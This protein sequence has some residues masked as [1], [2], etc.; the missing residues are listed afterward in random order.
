MEAAPSLGA[1]T[2]QD[3]GRA[4]LTL[5]DVVAQ[6]VGFIGPVFSAAFLLPSVAGLG[7]TGKGAGVASPLALIV[8]T[9]G[10]GGVAWIISRYAS[11]IHA[12]G[13]L[14]DYVTDGFGQRVGFFAGWIYYGGMSLL[15]FAIFPAFGGFMYLTLSGN[16]GVDI[17]WWILAL[18]FIAVC[19]GMTIL[20]VQISTRAQFVLAAVS[21]AVIFGWAVYVLIKGGT[22][23]GSAKPFDPGALGF[24]DLIYGLLYAT[25]IFT[26]FESAAN[27]A[28]ET[29]DPRR[30]IPR[31]V[32]YSVIAVGVFYVIVMY[33]LELA[34]G[35]DMAALLN[36]E[37]FP[38]LYSAAANPEIGGDTFGE[39]VQWIV[40]I[41]IAAVALGVSNA[42]SRGYFALARDGR[43]PRVVGAVHSR[44]MTPWIAALLLGVVSA[45]LVI[46]TEVTDG[47]VAGADTDPGVWF[48][49]FQFGATFGA[50]GLVVVYLLISVMGFKGLQ[51]ENR[52]GLAIAGLVG[53]AATIAAIVGTVYKAPPVYELNKVWWIMLIYAG[54]GA[55]V[56]ALLHSRGA[57]DQKTAGQARTV[58]HG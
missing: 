34:F 4:K 12:A 31:A 57:F 21:V 23:G 6:S 47:I 15:V 25:L 24:K 44:F 56:L 8:A 28:E 9:I 3:L 26:G 43:L 41:D 30:S 32:F 20:G 13:A 35:L 16:H 29:A 54:V 39:F 22:A 19:F 42:C 45:V 46:L 51:G 40:L 53:S 38:P 37:N 18:A 5:V 50:L 33:A 49:F 52:L 58:S 48:R 1:A 11:R 17:D 10:L 36:L 55:A 7:F 2:G 14:Y 27:L